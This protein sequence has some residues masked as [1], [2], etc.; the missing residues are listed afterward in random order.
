MI[1]IIPSILSCDFGRL[2]EE[3]RAVE[4][5]GADAIHIDV[6]D[7]H[8]VPNISI[9]IPIVRAVRAVTQLPIDCH[10]MIA[11]PTQYLRAF[12]EAGA[13]W[14]SVHVETCDLATAL[15]AI[16]AL[17][18]RAG[19]VLNPPTPVAAVLPYIGEADFFLVMSVDPGFAG[20]RFLPEA[21][22]KIRTLQH[23]LH[24]RTPAT[25]IQIDGGIT[26]ENV[27]RAKAAGASLIVAASAIF[28]GRD[29]AATIAALRTG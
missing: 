17:G 24:A 20:Q 6:M 23:A 8:F 22:E 2:A 19:A 28:Q 12:A 21:L 14:I 13:D 25:P 7:G 5:A 18:C 1:Q 10:L 4:A 26:I 11:H 29:Y 9:G 27:G 3:I 15:P 16:R